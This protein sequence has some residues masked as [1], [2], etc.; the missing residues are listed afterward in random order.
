MTFS[1]IQHD[2]EVI[3]TK[4]KRCE[5]NK[6]DIETRIAK[7]RSYSHGLCWCHIY[8]QIPRPSSRFSSK[9]NEFYLCFPFPTFYLCTLSVS[10]SYAVLVSILTAIGSSA[11][12]LFG[13]V[14]CRTSLQRALSRSTTPGS[15]INGHDCIQTPRRKRR[16]QFSG[17]CLTRRVVRSDSKQKSAATPHLWRDFGEGKATEAHLFVSVLPCGESSRLVL[18]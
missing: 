8:P 11:R 1:E 12:N 4:L 14:C 13:K 7:L 6:R 2:I 9:A 16:V 18:R 3:E 17:G 5:E 10:L 15:A